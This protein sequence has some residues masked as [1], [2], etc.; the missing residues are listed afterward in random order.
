LVGF[1]GATEVVPFYKAGRFQPL[2]RRPTATELA[3]EARK[4]GQEDDISV[5]EVSRTPVPEAALTWRGASFTH[6]GRAHDFHIVPSCWA[7]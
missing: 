6:S 4:P 3:G 1:I 5:I 7:C 2:N